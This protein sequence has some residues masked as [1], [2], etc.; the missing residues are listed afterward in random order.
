MLTSLLTLQHLTLFL[1]NYL[2]LLLVSFLSFAEGFVAERMAL[3]FQHFNNCIKIPFV[4]TQ[5]SCASATLFPGMIYFVRLR[6]TV[7]P[8]E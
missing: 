6:Y 2:F 3:G 8:K 1:S 4:S 7:C 5:N